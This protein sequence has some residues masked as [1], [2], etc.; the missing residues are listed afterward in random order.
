M[1]QMAC[2]CKSLINVV[3]VVC[4][5]EVTVGQSSPLLSPLPLHTPSENS[6][7]T[8]AC[9]SEE[10]SV[11]DTSK[12]TSTSKSGSGKKRRKR[13]K[14]FSRF[15]SS[16]FGH[17]PCNKNASRDKEMYDRQLKEKAD[18]KE[19]IKKCKLA[20]DVK[21]LS[22]EE[23]EKVLKD[24]KSIEVATDKKASLRNHTKSDPYD[25]L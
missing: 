20:T 16:N 3:N 23:R 18:E 8:N 10:Q 1:Y 14:T 11:I 5:A 25:P 17:K 12:S 7:K 4:D 2:E 22:A 13:K 6:S 15:V 24:R 19:F 21:R 9:A